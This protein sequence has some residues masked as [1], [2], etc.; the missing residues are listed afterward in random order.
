MVRNISL[1]CRKEGLILFHSFECIK[2]ARQQILRKP[3]RSSILRG[4]LV[5]AKA[6]EDCEV[7]KTSNVCNNGHFHS[8]FKIVNLRLLRTES[9]FVEV[10]SKTDGEGCGMRLASEPDEF[11]KLLGISIEMEVL[12]TLSVVYTTP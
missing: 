8:D 11:V 4:S 12:F 3:S 5:L 1:Y 2:V 6:R 9:S 7:E 10:Y